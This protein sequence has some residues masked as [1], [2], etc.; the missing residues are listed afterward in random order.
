MANDRLEPLWTRRVVPR[1]NPYTRGSELCLDHARRATR[2]LVVELQRAGYSA[3]D[4]R[5]V[6]EGEAA[7]ISPAPTASPR[8]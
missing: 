3:A 2:A 5:R 8:R 7:A 6:L 4:L 1:K